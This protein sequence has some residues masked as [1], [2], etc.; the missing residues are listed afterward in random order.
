ME[1]THFYV[2]FLLLSL[3]LLFMIKLFE[4][5]E[6]SPINLDNLLLAAKPELLRI[7]PE[8]QSSR[9]EIVSANLIGVGVEERNR[10]LNLINCLLVNYRLMLLLS[11]PSR[12]GHNSPSDLESCVGI[13]LD[14]NILPNMN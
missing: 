4:H 8:T 13:E 12:Q 11:R 2:S 7:D 5:Q 9:C 14:W 3:V 6:S 1:L 10:V